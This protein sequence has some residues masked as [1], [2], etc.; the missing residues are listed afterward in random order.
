MRF[1]RMRDRLPRQFSITRM[2]TVTWQDGD[3]H[4]LARCDDTASGHVE[5]II[6][7]GMWVRAGDRVELVRYPDG[8]VVSRRMVFYPRLVDDTRRFR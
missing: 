6:P 4:G 3:R 8:W 5:I 2:A 7:N 1:V